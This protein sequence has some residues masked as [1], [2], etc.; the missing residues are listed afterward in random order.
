MKSH[1]NYLTLQTIKANFGINILLDFPSFLLQELFLNIAINN[2]KNL[3]KDIVIIIDKD[4]I[5]ATKMFKSNFRSFKRPFLGYLN[6]A[7]DS[8]YS[9][10]IN[11]L[12][13]MTTLIARNFAIEEGIWVFD[14]ISKF[15]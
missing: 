7:F 13:N 5:A 6:S 12:H 10:F 8:H 14:Q 9:M 4:A 2:H 11:F 3:L 15:S 1:N